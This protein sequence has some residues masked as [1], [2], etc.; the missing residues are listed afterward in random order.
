MENSELAEL[1]HYLRNFGDRMEK[2]E[3]LLGIRY[4]SQDGLKSQVAALELWRVTDKYERRITM[5]LIYASVFLHFIEVSLLA[6]IIWR[7]SW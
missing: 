7:V 5:T 2:V 1:E 4:A 6:L 3:D